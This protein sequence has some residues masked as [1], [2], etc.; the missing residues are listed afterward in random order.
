[1]SRR[2][3]VL[4]TGANGEVGHGLIRRLAEESVPYDIVALDLAEIDGPLRSRCAASV[5]GSILDHHLLDRL[6]AE[7]EIHVV[8]HLAALLS[9]RGE[10]VPEMAHEVNVDGTVNLLRLAASEARTHGERVRFLFP[11]SIAV[12]GVPDLTRKAAS[13]PVREDQ[14]LE[15]ITMYGCNKLACEHLGRYYSRHYRQLAA[16]HE[17]PGVDFRCLRFPG[18]LSAETVPSGGTSDYGPELIH[19]AAKGVP[20]AAFVR[21]DTVM[22]FLAMPDAITALLDLLRAPAS[23][24]TTQVYN[25]AAF[26]PT[27]AEFAR[28]SRA[29]FPDAQLSF[30]PDR[31]RQ[32]ICD[33]WPATVDDSAARR[34]F[35]F[36]PAYDLERTFDDY[37]IPGVRARYGRG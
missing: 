13:G 31:A 24:L 20:Y 4:I 1:M 2:P 9:S 19:A 5:S 8:F 26:A 16:D 29:A 25:V 33:S 32:R 10:Y 34:D 15:P 21:E 27:A 14:F 7:F 11:S 35:G 17:G 37:L 18:L 22:P 3:V 23:N 30:V 6:Q 12:Y 36:R 28:R